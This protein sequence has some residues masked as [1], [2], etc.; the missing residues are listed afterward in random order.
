MQCVSRTVLVL[1]IL[2]SMVTSGVAATEPSAPKPGQV[3]E[4]DY[5]LYDLVVRTKYLRSD[6]AL[7]LV[8]RMTMTRRE[9]DEREYLRREFFDEQ[10]IFDG[11]LPA[12]LL[13]SFFAGLKTQARLESRFTFGTQVKFFHDGVPE[14]AEVS[15][16]PIL[17]SFKR[18]AQRAPHAI[19]VLRFSRIGYT[20]KEDQALLLVE[21]D[22]PDGSGGGLL[23]WLRRQGLV[24]RIAE[25]EVLWTARTTEP[26]LQGP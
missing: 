5:P 6:T 16:A 21:E 24:W 15:L 1:S 7:V 2:L 11:R 13:A 8:E 3:P 23:I 17:V 19:G 26:G 20:A 22:R 14:E 12:E 25:T 4:E 10:G 18:P 9:K